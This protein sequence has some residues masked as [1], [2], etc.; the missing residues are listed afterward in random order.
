MI[1]FFRRV[2][3]VKVKGLSFFVFG[4]GSLFF[5]LFVYPLLFI[6]IHPRER[7]S[8]ILRRMVGRSFKLFYLFM[9]WMGIVRMEFEGLD[10]LSRTRSSI[11]CANHPSLLDAVFLIG[12]VPDADCI[13]KATLW[14]NPIVR[15]I[16]SRL[17]IPNSL[18]P[19]ETV[20]V[21]G[22]S[23]GQGNNLIL[24]P[25]GTRTSPDAVDI[26]LSRSAAQIALRNNR[27]I[28]PVQIH[29]KSARGIGKGDHFFCAP[30]NGVF[31]YRV[32]VGSAIDVSGYSDA[33]LPQASRRL[34][35]KIKTAIFP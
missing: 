13:V 32:V 16:V 31:E 9:K 4:L 14:K 34:T 28:V 23:L 11:I 2:Y 17:F 33:P 19:M 7:L 1:N 35:D 12:H 30:P 26:R 6:L 8:K 27:N 22:K 29:N 10:E 21:C 20:K 18:D 25:E 5:A 3:N 15:P 24:F